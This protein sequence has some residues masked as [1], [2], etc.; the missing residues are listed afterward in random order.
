MIRAGAGYYHASCA[1]CHGAPG[2]APAGLARGLNPPAPRLAGGL[3]SWT[4]AEHYWIVKN[5]VR[6]SGMPA[7]ARSYDEEK[8]WAVVAFLNRLP[9]LSPQNYQS[10]IAPAGH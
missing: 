7:F 9:A 6:M 4:A 2:V 10:L 3:E 5:G 1:T 8:I